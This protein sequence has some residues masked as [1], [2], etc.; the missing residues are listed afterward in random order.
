M[1]YIKI[2]FGLLMS[3]IWGLIVCGAMFGVPS[4]L[5]HSSLFFIGWGSLDIILWIKNR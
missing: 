1:D 3:L 5:L 2:S 4:P